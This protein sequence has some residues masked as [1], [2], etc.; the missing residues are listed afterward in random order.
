MLEVQDICFGYDNKRQLL[1]HVSFCVPAGAV[2][3]LL[4]PN[5]AGKTTLLR[6]LLSLNRP[7]RGRI[8]VGGRD[9]QAMTAKTKARYVAYVPQSTT[10]VFS[11]Q[12]LEVVLMGRTPHLTSMATPG[13]NDRK[14]AEQALE[15]LGIGHLAG[16]QFDELSGGER[17]LTLIARALAQQAPVLIMDEPAA[18]LDYGNQVR[19]L[20][21]IRQLSGQGYTIMMS[22]HFPNHAFW[23]GSQVVLLQDGRVLAAGA[24][25][26][27][28]TAENLT[29]L[30]GTP[31]SVLTVT[32][33]EGSGKTITVCAPLMDE[34]A[35]KAEDQGRKTGVGQAC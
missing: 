33:S 24:P 6:C 15:Q 4:G 12:V 31:M 8:I 11:Y 26:E 9:L 23:A 19:I 25:A 34:Q 5:G 20:K 3:C 13:Q 14:I 29:S 32:P 22:T 2:L 10:A 27:V 7:S 30:Y 16:R 35:S 28:V 17:Q 21:L 1:Q 18:S